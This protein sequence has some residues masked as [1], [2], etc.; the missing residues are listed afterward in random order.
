MKRAYRAAD[1]TDAYL[2]LHRLQHAGIAARVLNEHAPGAL[3]EIPFMHAAPEV[4]L[5]DDADLTRA[6]TIVIEHETARGQSGT[7]RCQTCGED[8]PAGFELC[9]R[10][11]AVLREA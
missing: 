10:C 6:R 7:H 9:W 4:W 11:G 1:L 5:E 2:L 3:G 8:S